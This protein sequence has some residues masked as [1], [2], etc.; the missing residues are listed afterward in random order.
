M[1][2]GRDPKPMKLF[3][4]THMRNENYQKGVQQFMDSRAQKFMLSWIST[5]TI[6]KLL[7]FSNLLTVF[8]FIRLLDR[9]RDDC[10]THPELDP[11]LLLEI[12]LSSGPNR[13]QVYGIS[14]TMTKDMRAG[15][16]VLTASSLHSDL[17]F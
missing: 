7:F 1:I 15:C 6:H 16:S 14:N 9:Y 4:E 5:K 11:G 17:S 10:L 3:V 13:I 8:F 12:G 2:L